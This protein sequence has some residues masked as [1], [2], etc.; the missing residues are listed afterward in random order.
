MDISEERLSK[1]PK[2][3]QYYIE[4]LKCQIGRLEDE[5]ADLDEA[6]SDYQRWH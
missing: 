6:Y 1:L 5:V 2:W 3:A 4:D